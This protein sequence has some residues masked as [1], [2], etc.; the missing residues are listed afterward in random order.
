MIVIWIPD[1]ILS[2]TCTILGQ[3]EP[4]KTT[5]PE[6]E[7]PPDAV[8]S[9]R[10]LTLETYYI[11][12]EYHSRGNIHVVVVDVANRSYNIRVSQTV[13]LQMGTNYNIV[14]PKRIGSEL[15]F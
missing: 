7:I 12:G 11:C 13:C 9:T 6:P 14:R 15:A 2:L 1:T 5:G 4:G 8:P 3:R 10:A